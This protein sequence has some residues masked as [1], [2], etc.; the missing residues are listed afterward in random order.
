M[1]P[2]VISTRVTVPAVALSLHASRSGGPGG[3][4]VNKVSTKVEL[5]VDLDGIVGLTEEQRRRLR[6]LAAGRLDDEGRLLVTSQTT[7]S[8]LMNLADA[9]ERVRALVLAALVAPKRRIPTKP[10]RAGKKRR[11]D[12][13]SRQSEKKRNRRFR[14]D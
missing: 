1:D 12:A 10:T 7:R 11:L 9:R 13:K 5:R 2:I 3:Q 8:Q 14:D 6:A 4:N